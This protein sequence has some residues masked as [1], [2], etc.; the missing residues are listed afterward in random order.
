MDNIPLILWNNGAQ[1]GCATG[2]ACTDSLTVDVWDVDNGVTSC[3]RSTSK[4]IKKTPHV[5]ATN[6]PND[7]KWKKYN[8][9][10]DYCE[11]GT[12]MPCACGIGQ[13]KYVNRY[14]AYDYPHPLTGNS[15]PPIP[16]PC[17]LS[18]PT[19]RIVQ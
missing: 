9:A 1:A 15:K 6:D 11:G 12:D 18:P 13:G 2:G 7:P 3:S 14:E 17:K 16:S 19:L 8:G 4:Y 5:W 10:V